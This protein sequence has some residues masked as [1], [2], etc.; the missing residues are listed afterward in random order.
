[1]PTVEIQAVT[2]PAELRTFVKFPFQLYRGNRYWV[3]PLVRDEIQTLAQ[4]PAFEHC[5]KKYWLAKRDGQVV[6]RIAGIINHAENKKFSTSTARF[7]WIDFIDDPEVSA[8]LFQTVEDW[9]REHSKNHIHGP[10]GFSDFDKEGLLVE[11]FEELGT[12]ATIYN[13]AYYANHFEACGYQKSTDWVE[14]E[15][16][17]PGKIPPRVAQFSQKVQQRYGLR[18]LQVKRAS[19]LRSYA[20]EIFRLVNA[21]YSHL[22]GYVEL[23]EKQIQFYTDQYFGYVNPDF[24]STILNQQDEVVAFGLTMPSLSRALQKAK[25]ELF[26]FGFWHLYRALQKND[27]ADFYIIAIRQDYRSKGVHV[28]ILEKILTTCLKF[29]IPLAETNPELETNLQVQLIWKGYDR[30]QHKRRRCYAKE[31]G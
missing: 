12:F 8:K 4:N 1:M 20:P 2:T 6:G 22:Y 19:E 21:A 26:P 13:H 9:A 24:V 15:I 3:P 10:L 25:G 16:H 17:S 27:R 30:R 29:G 18:Q 14:Y 31:L 5:L 7:G 11:G 28:M 23:T